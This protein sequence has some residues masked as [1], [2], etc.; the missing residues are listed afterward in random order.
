[1]KCA[2]YFECRVNLEKALDVG[3]HLVFGAEV[4]AG[5]VPHDNLQT[6]T[7]QEYRRRKQELWK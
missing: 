5:V 7:Y 3:R 2:G 1:M 6:L 4:A